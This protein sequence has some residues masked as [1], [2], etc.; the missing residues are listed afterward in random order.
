[1]QRQILS[2]DYADRIYQ[3]HLADQVKS[4]ISTS[5]FGYQSYCPVA[6]GCNV[7]SRCGIQSDADLLTL[8][9][10]STFACLN[11]VLQRTFVTCGLCHTSLI[12]ENQWSLDRTANYILLVANG[13]NWRLVLCRKLFPAKMRSVNFSARTY[14][15]K[16]VQYLFSRAYNRF[17]PFS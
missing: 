6:K 16:N 1:M 9:S 7:M 3:T 10:M 4:P 15:Y 11:I 2:G 14:K 8:N 13:S 12:D 17:V 5:I